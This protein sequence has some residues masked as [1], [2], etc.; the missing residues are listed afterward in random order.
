MSWEVLLQT[1]L[2]IWVIVLKVVRI[3]IDFENRSDLVD[4]SPAQG[5]GV[6]VF[7]I[8]QSRCARPL[9]AF[10]CLRTPRVGCDCIF[11]KPEKDIRSHTGASC[12]F[13]H[14]TGLLH[15]H[16]RPCNGYGDRF[17]MDAAKGN[18]EVRSMVTPAKMVL[19]NII[20]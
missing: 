14:I 15:A 2:A 19:L 11:K 10:S 3:R 8:A 9:T 4:D 12:S 5:S 13:P 1:V 7:Q 17:M 16:S 18:R 6:I 20:G